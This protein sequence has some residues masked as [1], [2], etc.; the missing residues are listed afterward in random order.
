MPEPTHYDVL[1]LAPT[2]SAA[3][4]RAAYR[5]AARDHHPD[6]GGDPGRMQAVNA[7][8]AVLG[9]PERRATY[10]RA[11]AEAHAGRAVGAA[12]TDPVE[13]EPPGTA[14]AD[15]ADLDERPLRPIRGLQGWWAVLPPGVLVASVAL[16]VAAFVFTSPALLGMSMGAFML[17]GGLFVLAPLRAMA[18][19]HE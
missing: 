16:F 7:A 15:P 10:D 14:V 2:A 17:S 11:L 12:R 18:R 3:E 6:A 13:W 19:P 4:V 5:S 8:W 1:G 9:D